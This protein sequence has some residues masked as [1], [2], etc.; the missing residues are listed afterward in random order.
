MAIDKV[1]DVMTGKKL[2][3][4]ISK[5]DFSNQKLMGRKTVKVRTIN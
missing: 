3:S 4:D 2:L 5:Q 1:V